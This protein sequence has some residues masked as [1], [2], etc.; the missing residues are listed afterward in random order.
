MKEKKLIFPFLLIT[1][2]TNFPLN[3]TN[4]KFNPEK[5]VYHLAVENIYVDRTG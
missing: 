5:Y 2:C 4:S 1:G 3:M